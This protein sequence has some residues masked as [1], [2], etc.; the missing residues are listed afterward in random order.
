M[1]KKTSLMCISAA[2]SF[3]AKAKLVGR[4]GVEI[5]LSD[6]IKNTRFY[7]GLG[8][9]IIFPCKK[10]GQDDKKQDMGPD[11]TQAVQLLSG[12][13]HKNL[14]L[15][16]QAVSGVC[17]HC[18]ALNPD[19]WTISRNRTTTVTSSTIHI[20]LEYNCEKDE[21]PTQ[22]GHSVGEEES[23]LWAIRQKNPVKP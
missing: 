12:G 8:W 5:T 7:P 17:L 19:L 16:H 23:C 6:K 2:T 13:P 1:T 10:C 11:E 21:N 4:D 15:L 14:R 9:R 18:V 22:P 3:K 20:R